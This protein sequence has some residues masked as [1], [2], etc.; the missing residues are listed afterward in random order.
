MI[1]PTSWVSVW[2][3]ARGS[4]RIW[5]PFF[6]FVLRCPVEFPGK[7]KKLTPRPSFWLLPSEIVRGKE[8]IDSAPFFFLLESKGTPF[9]PKKNGGKMGRNPPGHR[10][11]GRL[12]VRPTPVADGGPRKSNGPCVRSRIRM[13][14]KQG[15]LQYTGE[16]KPY[17]FQ[18]ME[19]I[20]PG[21]F[22]QRSLHEKHLNIA[23]CR[24]GGVHFFILVLKK[25]HVT[26]M[27]AKWRSLLR[28]PATA[29][30][31]PGFLL[32]PR[33]IDWGSE[34]VCRQN[35]GPCLQERKPKRAKNRC[36]HRG[37]VVVADVAVGEAI[38]QD[39]VKDLRVTIKTD[40]LLR[41]ICFK[42]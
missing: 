5:V 22:Q 40:R 20:F 4:R 19:V 35:R 28:S 31:L 14:Q 37:A 17:S 24:Y 16:I 13:K 21:D 23:T 38:H 34:H 7:R 25:H 36:V 26:Q 39:A 2:P 42:N 27:V 41:N 10:V 15:S 29:A 18:Q 30:Y 33:L 12:Q 9:P 32:D 8:K 1:G 6:V 11:S 3:C